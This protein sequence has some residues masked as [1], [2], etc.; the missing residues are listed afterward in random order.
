[1]SSE[2]EEALRRKDRLSELLARSNKKGY[3]WY[4]VTEQ[5]RYMDLLA[6]ENTSNV[7]GW[8]TSTLTEQGLRQLRQ[9]ITRS[10]S[11]YP[12]WV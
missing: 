1:M 5:K 6:L 12:P 7:S 10:T 3:L 4:S 11:R 2:T 9:G 8:M